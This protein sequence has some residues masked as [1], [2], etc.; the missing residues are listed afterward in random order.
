VAL[1]PDYATSGRAYV[2]HD[3]ARRPDRIAPLH[4]AGRQSATRSTRERRPAAAIPHTRNNHNGGWLGFGRDGLL[5]MATGDG[6]G[7]NDPDSNGRTATRCS[8]RCLRL[9]VARDDFPGDAARDYGIP[10]GNPFAGGRRGGRGVALWPAQ[11]VPQQL[12]T[13]PPASCGSATSAGRDRGDRPGAD[14]PAALNLGW[15]LYEGTLPL[16]GSDPRGPDDAGRPNTATAR[17]AAGQ[18]GDR[19][20][21]LSAGRSN[22]C[23]ACTSSPTSSAAT[24]GRFPP[25]ASSPARPSRAAASPTATPRSRPTPGSLASIASFGEDQAGNLYIVAFGGDVFMIQPIN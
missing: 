17:T 10:A 24:C 11:P 18:L 5:Y 4:L 6:G 3:R 23:R 19:R 1:A 20:V 16:L 25:R 15:P 14:H 21:R 8:A 22:R 13:G 12:S 2:Y 7:A 9:D